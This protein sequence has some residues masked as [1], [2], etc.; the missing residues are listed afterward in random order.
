MH[1]NY[2]I[3]PYLTTIHSAGISDS[4][5]EHAEGK[6]TFRATL[7]THFLQCLFYFCPCSSST[8]HLFFLT[9]FLVDSHH[10]SLN[11]SLLTEISIFQS[12]VFILL[13]HDFFFIMIIII[14]KP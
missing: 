2:I 7:R 5:K 10:S 9:Y 6:G 13:I 4:K 1:W 14:M 12:L 8:H 3:L 11:F